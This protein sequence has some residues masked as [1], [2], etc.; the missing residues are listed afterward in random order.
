MPEMDGLE[1]TRRI[2]QN[3]AKEDQ[4]MIIAMTANAM[5]GDRARCMEAGMDAYISKPIRFGEIQTILEQCVPLQTQQNDQEEQPP[6][7]LQQPALDMHALNS[8]KQEMGDEVLV[9][10]V[11][12]YVDESKEILMEIQ[13]TADARQADALRSAAHSLKGASLNMSALA[14]AKTCETIEQNARENNLND[15]QSLVQLA[16]DQHETTCTALLAVIQ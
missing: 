8:L 12:L 16:T 1:A 9:E 10:L 5:T 4:P 11:Q 2:R 14:L 3:F 6:D 15:M 7:E 13:K